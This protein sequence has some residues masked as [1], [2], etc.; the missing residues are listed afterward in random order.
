MEVIKIK[1]VYREVHFKSASIFPMSIYRSKSITEVLNEVPKHYHSEI[2]II[3]FEKGGVIYEIDGT[4]FKISEESILIVNRDQIHSGTVFNFENHKNYVFIFDL[5]ILEGSSDD[6][7]SNKYIFPIINKEL[8]FPKLISNVNPIFL[9]VKQLL[10]NI[11]NQY[12]KK[13]ISYELI[14]KAD[15]Y[16]IVSLF[17]KN[18][19][20]EKAYDKI[21]ENNSHYFTNKIIQF[22]SLNYHKNISKDDLTAHLRVTDSKLSRL[23]KKNLNSNFSDY[24]ATYRIMKATNALLY[25]Q[26]SITDISFDCGFKD[27]SYFIRIFKKK[28]G[29]SPNSYRKKYIWLKKDL[30]KEKVVE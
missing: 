2:E 9:E 4:P 24:L 28:I 11:Y 29:L 13:E 23:F 21:A 14:I 17:Y 20:M 26:L 12:E 3:F 8:L 15:L 6:I 27:I 10:I 16:K 1:T 22:I 25:T 7:F 19:L 30:I 5:S 18:N